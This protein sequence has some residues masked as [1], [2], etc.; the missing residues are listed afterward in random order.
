MARKSLIILLKAV[1]V[2]KNIKNAFKNSLKIRV[3]SYDIMT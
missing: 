1:K 2:N 3:I